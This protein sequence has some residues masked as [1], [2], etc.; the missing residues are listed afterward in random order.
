MEAKTIYIASIQSR[1]VVFERRRRSIQG[2]FKEEGLDVEV[3]Q[4][5][6]NVSIAAL[7]SGNMD[8]NLFC[9]RSSPPISAAFL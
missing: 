1:H 8:Y 4:M 5:N 2:Y 3:L 7:A 9:S 6:A